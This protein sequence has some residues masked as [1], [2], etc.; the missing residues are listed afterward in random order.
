[1]KKNFSIIIC[2]GFMVNGFAQVDPVGAYNRFM[3]ENWSGQYTRVGQNKVKGSPHLFGKAFPG[4][5]DYGNGMFITKEKVL[6]NLLDQKAGPEVNG[7]IFEADN[8]PMQFILELPREN[9]GKKLFKHS[10]AYGNEKLNA[11]FNVVTD[12]AYVALLKAYKI[13]LSPDPTNMMDKDLKL[14]EQYTEY[15]VFVHGNGGSLQKIKLKKKDI[16][17]VLSKIPGAA[18]KAN[19][20]NGD[21]SN[22]DDMKDLFL[23]VNM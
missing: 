17:D 4:Q 18:E 7:E 19:K 16:M 11:Y 14:F 21:F 5:I 9:G 20:S 15:Y 13:K 22:E 2:L 12:G 10:S 3:A 6:Y 8:K 1:M 23:S